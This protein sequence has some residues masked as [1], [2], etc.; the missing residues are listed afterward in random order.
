MMQ[1]LQKTATY[2]LNYSLILLLF[3]VIYQRGDILCSYKNLHPDASNTLIQNSSL[4]RK[5]QDIP[6]NVNGQREQQWWC[7]PLINPTTPFTQE[8]EVEDSTGISEQPVLLKEVQG[9]GR[10]SM[11]SYFVRVILLQ[12]GHLKCYHH[13]EKSVCC[14]IPMM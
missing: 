10:R 11:D 9:K 5:N 4:I 8:A 2:K 1:I 3:P 12:R 14:M 6:Q 13:P 7:T